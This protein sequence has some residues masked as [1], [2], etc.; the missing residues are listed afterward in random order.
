MVI[1]KNTKLLCYFFFFIDGF[2]GKIIR[3]SGEEVEWQKMVEF[4]CV[5]HRKVFLVCKCPY[6]DYATEIDDF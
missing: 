1:A 6:Q 3:L 4:L 2:K 5:V